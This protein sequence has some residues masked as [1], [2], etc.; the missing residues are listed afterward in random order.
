M[1]EKYLAIC[2]NTPDICDEIGEE[3]KISNIMMFVNRSR[4]SIATK[5][6]IGRVFRSWFNAAKTIHNMEDYTKADPAKVASL[7]VLMYPSASHFA[8]ST[9]E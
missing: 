5:R 7:I 1:G 6:P 9:S 3:F 4:S 8:C 2:T